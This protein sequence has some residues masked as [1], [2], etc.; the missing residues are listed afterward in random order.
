MNPVANLS[1]SGPASKTSSVRAIAAFSLA[2]FLLITASAV[3]QSNQ[4]GLSFEDDRYNKLP[5]NPSYGKVEHLPSAI[6]FKSVPRVINQSN[7]NTAV[8]WST[9]WYAA[10]ML[11]ANESKTT[12]ALTIQRLGLSA[13]FTYRSAAG[14][15]G[16]TQPVSLIDALESLKTSGAPRFSDFRELCVDSIPR[17][18]IDSARHH[19]IQSFIRLFNTYDSK[20]AKVDAI[21]AALAQGSPVVI[22][23]ICPPSFNLA[24]EFWQPREQPLR[25]YGGHA[26]TIVGYDDAMYQG[27][28]QVVNSWGRSWGKEGLTWFRYDDIGSYVL[29]GFQL[30]KAPKIFSAT[31]DFRDGQKQAM[32]VSSA[33]P[34]EYVFKKAY[35]TGDQFNFRVKTT[36]R[37]FMGVVAFDQS[38]ARQVLDVAAYPALYSNLTLPAEDK[39]YPLTEPVGKNTIIFVF[40]TEQAVLE[41][42]IDEIQSPDFPLQNLQ[43]DPSAISIA[44]RASVVVARV[45]L[46]QVP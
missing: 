18:A 14:Q 11:D 22:G 3:G 13:A 38:G 30:T 45:V 12:D 21:K 7:T 5:L 40:S 26:I 29:Y 36:G 43:W 16:C 8:G 20:Q 15:P 10:T 35:R 39:Y 1:S 23:F 32:A 24:G 6:S 34:G 37:V 19:R 31:V 46:N 2:V 42:T 4:R 33:A 9:A 17:Y 28:F 41:K 27:S 25:E 44:T